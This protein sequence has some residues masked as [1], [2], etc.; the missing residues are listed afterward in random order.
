MEQALLTFTE[1]NARIDALP[2]HPSL[3][4]TIRKNTY[5][6]FA[7]AAT[8]SL[9]SLLCT[10]LLPNNQLYT[11]VLSILFL[12]VE[13]VGIVVVAISELPHRWPSIANER[14][15][16]AEALDHDL[17]HHLGLLEWLQSFPRERLQ[18]LSEYASCRHER[19]QQKL[20]LFIGNIEK[21]GL[22]PVIAALYLQFKDLR[23]PPH[24]SWLD[25]ALI[26]IL[27]VGYATS[28]L[29]FTVRLRLQLYDVLLKNAL[30]ELDR[31]LSKSVASV[32][33]PPAQAVA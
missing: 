10:K 7:I 5:R 16:F 13:L 3:S 32:S 30:L 4:T 28:L 26:F 14:R 31:S 8:G 18:Q 33:E 23:W 2:V 15:Q 21:L 29:Q 9:L 22:L 11:A 24:P 6:G 17:P 20:P 25:I 12:V 27:I 19:M 1:F